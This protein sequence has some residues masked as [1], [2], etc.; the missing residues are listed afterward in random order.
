MHKSR[1]TLSCESNTVSMSEKVIG[2][3]VPAAAFTRL[4][5]LWCLLMQA[6]WMKDI[7]L[8]SQ[9]D[10][11]VWLKYRSQDSVALPHCAEVRLW[12]RCRSFQMKLCHYFQWFMH[13]LHQRNNCDCI[14]MA[15]VKDYFKYHVLLIYLHICRRDLMIWRRNFSSES[16]AAVATDASRITCIC[17]R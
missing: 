16:I 1:M 3:M 17:F 8:S 12:S 4:Q 11:F 9:T 10:E 14:H 6:S 5:Y 2:L 13:C 15:L 7:H